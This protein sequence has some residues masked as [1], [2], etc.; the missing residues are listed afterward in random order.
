MALLDPQDGKP[1]PRTTVEI[2]ST[3]EPLQAPV[4][5][6]GLV[7]VRQVGDEY[8][9]CLTQVKAKNPAEQDQVDFGLAK[10]TRQYRDPKTGE[11]IDARN[12]QVAHE[13]KDHLEP[14][15]NTLVKE[16]GKE[17]GLSERS[18]KL[19]SVQLLGSRLFTSRDKSPK[20]REGQK[21]FPHFDIEWFVIKADDATVNSMAEKAEEMHR[22][23]WFTLPQIDALKTENKINP[24]YAQVAHE[25]VEKL[26][27]NKLTQAVFPVEQLT[28]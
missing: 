8:Q 21:E 7:L 27:E 18:V 23:D 17:L 4:H 3:L 14:I 1:F 16:A 25:A 28:I 6:V 19:S 13:F 11:M 2:K 26:R 20:M 9:V 10:G 12:W 15:Y 5:K 24:C 22:R